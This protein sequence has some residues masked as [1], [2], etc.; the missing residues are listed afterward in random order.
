MWI[1][2]KI[3]A[4]MLVNNLRDDAI[5]NVII[6]AYDTIQNRSKCD[7]H[8]DY[9]QQLE[10]WSGLLILLLERLNLFHLTSQITQLL[11]IWWNI[12]LWLAFLSPLDFPYIVSIAKAG[13][14]KIGTLIWSWNLFLLRLLVVSIN[15][16][17][18]LAWNIVFMA[19]L[20]LLVATWILG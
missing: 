13:P 16:L 7:Q 1:L 11:L 3:Y 9:E 20:V 2:S 5:F 10:A 17:H 6:Y 15:L 18:D 4:L 8:S 19:G 14:K 12:L